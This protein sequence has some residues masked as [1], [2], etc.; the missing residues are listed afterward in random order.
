MWIIQI[1]VLLK[2]DASTYF[3]R[4]FCDV[5]KYKSKYFTGFNY[6]K[7]MQRVD[8]CGVGPYVLSPLQLAVT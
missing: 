3:V 8:M 4:Y 6:I 2:F 5:L 7:N 1:V